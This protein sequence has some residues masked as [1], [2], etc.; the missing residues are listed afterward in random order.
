[1]EIT[2]HFI[3]KNEMEER[4][5]EKILREQKAI[6]RRKVHFEKDSLNDSLRKYSLLNKMNYLCPNCRTKNGKPHH[7][8]FGNK[9][10]EDLYSL[11]AGI[12]CKGCNSNSILED[13]L[14]FRK[15]LLGFVK[16]NIFHNAYFALGA[17]ESIGKLT[18]QLDQ[19]NQIDLSEIGVPDKSIIVDVQYTPNGRYF[20]LE[21]HSN[22]PRFKQ[23][24]RDLQILLWPADLFSDVTGPESFPGSDL[25]VKVLWLNPIT[26]Y[27]DTSILNAINSYIDDDQ[28][29][30]VMNSNIALEIIIGNICREE[31]ATD[32]CSDKEVDEFLK[33]HATYSY[34]LNILLSYICR[35]KKY[36]KINNEILKSINKIRDYR[37]KIVHRGRITD[38]NGNEILLS[39]YQ[40][41]EIITDLL[42]GTA[43]LRFILY[44]K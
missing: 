38:K 28:N 17:E 19:I 12:P 30:I 37:N 23:R 26:D 20:P 3:S 10:F 11:R 34:Q 13:Q 39:F 4:E 33:N 18:M 6:E 29:G 21:V 8:Q 2:P 31:L 41:A 9:L 42:I 25:C 32:T 5:K 27:I 36:V 24:Y 43:L 35:V 14:P 16:A 44:N 1:M 22:D 40:K 15:E 7:D